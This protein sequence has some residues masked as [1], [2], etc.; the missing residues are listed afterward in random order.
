MKHL[1]TLL[2]MWV[3]P[4]QGGDPPWHLRRKLNRR[5]AEVVAVPLEPAKSQCISTIQCTQH[6]DM[7]AECSEGTCRCGNDYVNPIAAA[8]GVEPLPLMHVCINDN[9]V[10]DDIIRIT[11]NATCESLTDG[12]KDSVISAVEAAT[13]GV[14]HDVDILC[15]LL[16]IRFAIVKMRTLAAFSRLRV[17]ILE[18]FSSNPDVASSG[19]GIP[20]DISLGSVQKVICGLSHAEEVVILDG[21]CVPVV[22]A[23]G[24]EFSET[25]AV[26][27]CAPHRVENTA[28]LAMPIAVMASMYFMLAVLCIFAFR[29]QLVRQFPS[30]RGFRQ[31]GESEVRTRRD[32]HPPTPCKTDEGRRTITI[33][34]PSGALDI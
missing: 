20:L 27:L 24:Y 31:W 4:L 19:L 16:H 15:D 30:L 5:H 14:V 6:G 25:D 8:V 32:H 22:C 10:T 21:R 18:S 12:H 34:S 9:T 7:S 29:T 28:K 33:S 26:L 3:V 11:W 17:D 2:L 13:G 23:D 1:L